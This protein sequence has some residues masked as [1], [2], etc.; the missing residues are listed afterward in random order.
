MNSGQEKLNKKDVRSGIWTFI[1][2]FIILSGFSFLCISMLFESSKRQSFSI[3]EDMKHY[4]DFK[5]ND[6]YIQG[7]MNSIFNQMIQ[8]S[9]DNYYGNDKNISLIKERKR[10]IIEEIN[11]DTIKNYKHFSL[12]LDNIDKMIELK[13]QIQGL[14]YEI[15]GMRQSINDCIKLKNKKIQR[16]KEDVVPVGRNAKY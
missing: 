13:Q 11:K 9:N 6:I 7:K 5:N 2:S 15:Y 10:E 14:N 1:L 16:A 3:E 4:K 12:M 8:I